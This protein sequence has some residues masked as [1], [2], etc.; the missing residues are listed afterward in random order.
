MFPLCS[1]A[2]GPAMHTRSLFSGDELPRTQKEAGA[3]YTPDSVVR[4][5]IRWAIRNDTDRFLDP[6][7][8]DGRFIAAHQN[9]VGIE[10]DIRSAHVAIQRAPWSL[11]HEGDFFAW[12]AETH[13]RFNATGGNPPFIRYQRF[14]GDVRARALELCKGLGAN[15]SG[16][17][18]SWAPFLVAS[19][20]LLEAGGRLAFVVPAEIGHAPYAA[21]VLDYLTSKFDIVHVIAYREKLFPELSEDCWLLYAEGFGGRTTEI[22]FSAMTHFE[23]SSSPPSAFS[24]IAIHEWRQSWNCRLRPLILPAATRDLYHTMLHHPDTRRLKEL[25][26]VGIGYVTGDNDFFHLR[27]SEAARWKIPRKFLRPTVRKAEYLP[28]DRLTAATVEKWHRTDGQILLLAIPKTTELPDSVYNYLHTDAARIARQAYKCRN[29]EPW[30]SVP[31]VQTPEFFMSYMSGREP[32]LVRN[33]AGCTCTNSIHAVRFKTADAAP[34]VRAVWGTEF[35]RL[36]C[37]LKGHPLGGGLLKLEPGEAGRLPVPSPAA[38]ARL[39]PGALAEALATMRA[40]R[41]YATE[42]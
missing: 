20:G 4:T 40:W 28:A 35:L 33:D 19:A 2:M 34:A 3:Y 26:N 27:P 6:A 5:L 16:L 30:Y 41:H 23:P 32:S 42:V 15:F 11:V 24:R 38:I 1:D 10:Q 9:S 8:G 12:A 18:S 21:P 29:R 39:P 22:C 31:D 36:S 37:E 14:K 17:A 7:C 13:E 25:A